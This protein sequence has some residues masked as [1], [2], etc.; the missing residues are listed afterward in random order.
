MKMDMK[1]FIIAGEVSGD[2]HG[3][4][5]VAEL[6]KQNP[7]ITLSGIGGDQ[8]MQHG[9]NAIYHIRQMAYLESFSYS[10]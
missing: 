6:K 7:D 2:I 1:L 10:C 4:K 9:F 3:G 8:M 5:L